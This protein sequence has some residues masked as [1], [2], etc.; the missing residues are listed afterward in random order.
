MIYV[1]IDVASQKHDYF[2][3][4][5]NGE[6]YT[7]RSITISNTDEGYKKLHKSIQEFCGATKDY[8]VRIGLESTE[9]YHYNIV[10][11]LLSNNYEVMIINPT[12]IHLDKKSH[13]V[14]IQKNDNLDAIAIC[15]YLEDRKTVFKPYTSISYHT[16]A[17]KALSR[18]RFSLVEELRKAKIMYISYYHSFFL[19]I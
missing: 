17:L 9:F 14:H 7:H 12:L 11:Y 19:N 18:D 5:S 4:S 10:S 1:G 3:R 6:V 8:E 15:D 16:E 2:I 13:K